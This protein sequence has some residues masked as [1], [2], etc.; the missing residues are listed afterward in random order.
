[1]IEQIYANPHVTPEGAREAAMKKCMAAPN[2][3]DVAE[4][5]LAMP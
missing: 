1:V 2:D 5:V 3:E 4:H